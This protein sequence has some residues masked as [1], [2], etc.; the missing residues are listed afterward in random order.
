MKK[1]KNLKVVVLAMLLS[2]SLTACG[3]ADSA[4][5]SIANNASGAVSDDLYYDNDY[6]TESAWEESEWDDGSDKSESVSSNRKLIKTVDLTAETYEFDEL[7]STVE[8]RVAELGGYM[9]NASVHTKYSDLKYGDFVIRIPVN[10]MDKF[11]ME[12][13]EISNITDKDTSQKDVTLSYVDM[14]SHKAA[15]E[16]EEKSLLNL[17]ENAASIEDI[18]ALQSRL[19]DVRYQIES[20]ESQL[21]TMDNLIEYATINL[22]I[23]EVETYTPVEDPSMGERISTGFK[24]SLDDVITGAENFV[25][26]ILANSP[27]LIIWAVLIAIFALVIRL[28]V[29]IS[30]KKMEASEEK[31]LEEQRKRMQANQV[32]AQKMSAPQNGTQNGQGNGK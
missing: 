11:V 18:I 30:I 25:V 22:Y 4:F 24:S 16:A 29:K 15:L 23:E 21:R 27:I 19:T 10:K 28:I 6:K 3:S 5:E 13:A 31:R 9:E 17:L 14:E 12:F 2:L 7:V 26:F 1:C 8:K 32:N 20:M